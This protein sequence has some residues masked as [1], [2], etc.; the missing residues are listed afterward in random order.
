ML[1]VIYNRRS[2]K[3]FLNK[4]I[5]RELIDKVIKA[6]TLAATGRNLQS[7][8][9][10]C[11]N[12]EELRNRLAKA[13]AEIMGVNIDPFYGAPTVLIVLAKKDVST[14]VYDGSLVMGNM[15]LAAESLGLGSCWI[16]RA[17]EVFETELGREILTNL[18][19][20]DEYEGIGNLVI[21][22]KSPDYQAKTKKLKDDWVYYID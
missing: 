14:H 1:D 11:V 12:N 4:K 8:I 17:R 2:T 9:I 7:P 21:G 16:H 5:D 20:E 15:M 3:K 10:I 18:A 22:Y 6:G 13:N 19:I